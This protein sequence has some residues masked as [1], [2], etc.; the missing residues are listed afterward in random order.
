LG[1]ASRRPRAAGRA[2]QSDVV[3]V[4]V[5]QFGVEVCRED[6]LLRGKLQRIGQ[7]VVPLA[8]EPLPVGGSAI[9]TVNGHRPKAV[10]EIIA[11]RAQQSLV[12]L[13]ME[14]PDAVV[15][16]LFFDQSQAALAGAGIEEQHAD[17][18]PFVANKIWRVAKDAVS[19]GFFPGRYSGARRFNRVFIHDSHPVWKWPAI[20]SLGLQ[21]QVRHA[22]SPAV[23]LF[24][25]PQQRVVIVGIPLRRGFPGWPRRERARWL[26]FPGVRARA[27][28]IPCL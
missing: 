2:L 6:A 22:L 28:R 15:L 7:G 27:Q 24:Q 18:H 17:V 1:A 20:A 13:R 9:R 25:E 11:E 26:V 14:P 5:L 4:E 8:K 3:G 19:A 12:S 21:N 16:V 10:F 23:Q